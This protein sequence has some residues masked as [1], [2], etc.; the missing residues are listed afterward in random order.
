MG[1]GFVGKGREVWFDIFTGRW[2]WEV[3]ERVAGGVGLDGW[4]DR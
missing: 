3:R 2:D 4:M 1:G